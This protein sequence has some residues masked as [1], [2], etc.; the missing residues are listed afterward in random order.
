MGIN[1]GSRAHDHIRELRGNPDFRGFVDAFGEKA[2]DIIRSSLDAPID[3]RVD[4]TSYAKA[5]IDIWSA[6]TAEIQGIGQGR[7]RPPAPQLAEKAV[8]AG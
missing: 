1:L 2:Q 7:V 8:R 5:L 6:M 3:Q 4:Q